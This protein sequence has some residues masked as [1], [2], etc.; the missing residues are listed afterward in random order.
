M[1]RILLY[2]AFLIIWVSTESFA[3]FRSR[4]QTTQTATTEPTLNYASPQEYTIAGI[5]VTGLNVLDKNA[6]VSLTGLKVGD[7]IKIPGDGISGA[8]RKLWKHG[9]VGDV[10]IA[11]QKIEGTNVYLSVI[12]TERPRLNDFYFVGISKGRQSALKDDLKLIKGKIVN[13]ATIRNAELSVKKHFVKKGFLNT[14]VKVTP[15][16]DT[17]NRGGTRL[18]IDVDLKSKVKINAVNINGNH[19]IADSKLK[20]KLKKTHE[21][22]RFSIH[23]AI[24]GEVLAFRPS[25]IGPALDSSRT[26]SWADIKAF[27]NR[28]VK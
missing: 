25:K 17:L 3:Q 23:R 19:D 12:L 1:K 14:V 6:M 28:N 2:I 9:L 20:H 21:H 18:K 13:D 7:K 26:T 24:L 16:S 27:A 22:P 10:T 5:E 4:N 11:V 15:Q 8:I